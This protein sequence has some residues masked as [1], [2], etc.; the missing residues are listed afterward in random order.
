MTD[1]YQWWRDALGGKNPPIHDGEPHSGY[2]KRRLV[3]GGPWVPAAIWDADG[4][5]VCRV[6]TETRDAYDEW[7]WLAKH[8]VKQADAKVAFETGAWPG[9]DTPVATAQIGGNNPPSEIT[10]LIPLEISNADAWLATVKTIATQEQSDIASNKVATLRGLKKKAETAH[11][12][13]KA[14]HLKAGRDV[15]AKY[16]PKIKDAEDALK[17]L[18]AAVTVFQNAEKARLQAIA[19][20]AA[21]IENAKRQAEFERQRDIAAKAAIDAKANELPPPPVAAPVFVAPEPVKIKSGGAIG[22]TVGLRKVKFAV[23]EDIEKALLALKGHKDMIDMV[24]T[25]ANRACKAGVPLA[26]VRFDEREEA[27]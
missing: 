21:R 17:R 11:E 19:D 13:E 24:Q 8:P 14:P 26:G 18:L 16:N 2:F 22:K 9:D 25:L 23:V 6:G 27:A 10:D 1:Q 4:R 3:K 12:T 5:K 7:T 15:D 20:E